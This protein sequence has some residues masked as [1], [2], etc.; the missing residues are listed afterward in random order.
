MP[1]IHETGLTAGPVSVYFE[2]FSPAV[3]TGKPTVVMVNGGA[4]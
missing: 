2:T 1:L 3:A 4:H